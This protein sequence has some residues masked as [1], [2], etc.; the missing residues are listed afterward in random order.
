MQIVKVTTQ[1]F[2]GIEYVEIVPNKTVTVIGGRNRQGKTSLLTSIACTLGGKKLCPERPIRTGEDTAR[3]SVD[4]DGDPA[5][6]IPPITV[7]REFFRKSN[8]EIDSKLEIITKD[9]YAAPSPQTLLGDVCGTIGF[10]PSVLLRMDSKKQAEVLRELVGLDFSEL[11]AKRA[12]IY[13]NRTLLGR[14]GK[15]LRGQLDGCTQHPDAPDQEVSVSALAA[16]L[17][18]DHAANAKNEVQRQ[19]L[20]NLENKAKEAERAIAVA[21]QR[22]SDLKQQLVKEEEWLAKSQGVHNAA[23]EVV[24]AQTAI[25]NALK[26]KDTSDTEQKIATAEETNIKVRA[27]A[28]KIDLKANVEAKLQEWKDATS[29]IEAIDAQK[30]KMREEAKWP[31][32]GLGYDETG[33]TYNGVP[34]VQ[35]SDYE[36]RRVAIGICVAMNPVLKFAFLKDSSLL[37]EDGMIEFASLA[38][39]Q[40]VQLFLERVGKGAECN[41]VIEGGEVESVDGVLVEKPVVEESK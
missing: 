13:E 31:V 16:Q 33:M 8:G 26:D 1:G 20:R 41:I 10:D 30:Q 7:I 34:F 35:A 2:M 11:D 12:K 17:K 37:D 22:V 29:E 39:E 18:A 24:T 40:G 23:I 32:P 5:R 4:L 9:G 28:K 14:E 21:E 6:L 25:V 3:V 19:A 38:A 15:S 27:N 36:Q